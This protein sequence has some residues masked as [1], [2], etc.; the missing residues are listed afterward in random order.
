[1]DEGQTHRVMSQPHQHTSSS[2]R[3][4]GSADAEDIR[5]LHAYMDCIQKQYTNV[6]NNLVDFLFSLILWEDQIL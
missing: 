5:V 1:M 4:R 3:D 6:S 2:V